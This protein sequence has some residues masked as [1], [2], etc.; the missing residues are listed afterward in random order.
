MVVR[1]QSR[2]KPNDDTKQAKL[3]RG[4]SQRKNKT[5]S[6]TISIGVAERELGQKDPEQVIKAA[7]QALYRAKKKGRNQVS[8]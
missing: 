6:V 5:L 3:K 1:E 7:D 8:H 4:Q 2:S